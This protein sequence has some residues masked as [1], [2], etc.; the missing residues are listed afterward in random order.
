MRCRLASRAALDWLFGVGAALA[1]GQHAGLPDNAGDAAGT[2]RRGVQDI[3][4]R[5][6]LGDSAVSTMYA[7]RSIVCSVAAHCLAAGI[8]Q[9]DQASSQS[10]A[11]AAET[12][13][14]ANP[15]AAP[16]VSLS[17][18]Q[19]AL[20]DLAPSKAASRHGQ[21]EPR[22]SFLRQRSS[23]RLPR[24]WHPLRAQAAA[25]TGA[26][27]PQAL[28]QVA[29]VH[30]CFPEEPCYAALCTQ[31][32]QDKE[33]LSTTCMTAL[34]LFCAGPVRNGAVAPVSLLAGMLGT[35]QAACIEQLDAA[36]PAWASRPQRTTEPKLALASLLRA[37]A[38]LL[39]AEQM[40]IS[41][42]EANAEAAPK[43]QRRLHGRV[44]QHMA[45]ASSFLQVRAQVLLS[46][47]EVCRL[48]PA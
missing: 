40:L 7:S 19:G 43:L 17:F 8:P 29:N 46:S 27:Q 20:T 41:E 4:G 10:P 37:A 21:H 28:W 33:V 44:G 25:G 32:S 9:P 31:A 16:G 3:K 11:R 39:N 35:L 26:R 30:C 24:L 48:T 47:S 12:T 1:A 34:H 6:D 38:C 14:P 18:L 2:G 36:G 22:P 42:Q 23:V 5:G 13:A 15:A 45:L